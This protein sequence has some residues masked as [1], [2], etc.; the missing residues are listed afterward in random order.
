M[1]YKSLA[2]ADKPPFPFVKDAAGAFPNAAY[3]TGVLSFDQMVQAYYIAVLTAAQKIDP[4][5]T[6]SND[7][8]MVVVS[9]GDKSLMLTGS[10]WN[11]F[12]CGLASAEA[13]LARV[14]IVPPAVV[15]PPHH[16]P[17]PAENPAPFLENGRWYRYSLFG[18]KVLCAAPA[19]APPG[20]VVN[21]KGP[22]FKHITGILAEDRNP[23]FSEETVNALLGMY[24]FVNAMKG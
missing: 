6:I 14:G 3:P 20:P 17:D 7:I 13:Q 24:T 22:I 1:R 2:P 15:I 8:G 4:T 18:I 12:N 16:D 10:L 21:F 11:E 23:P 9:V 5:A 19:E